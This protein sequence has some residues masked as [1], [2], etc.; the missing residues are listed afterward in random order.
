VLTTAPRARPTVERPALRVSTTA[1]RTAVPRARPTVEPPALRVSTTVA[2]TVAPMVVLM[3]V[4]MAA[5]TEE[6]EHEA[7]ERGRRPH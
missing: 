2:R 3:V 1:V 7:S 6:P 5:P 4:L